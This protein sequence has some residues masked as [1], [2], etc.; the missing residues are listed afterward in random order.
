M[1]DTA[2][3]AQLDADRLSFTRSIRLARRQVTAQAAFSPDHLA[4]FLA[5]GL[6][7]MARHLLP[8]RR[9]RFHPRVLQR[10][11]SNFGGKRDEHRSPPQPDRSPAEAVAIAPHWRTA[12]INP[13][14]KVPR[15]WDP[16]PY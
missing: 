8:D 7:E 12:S 4:A 1:H 14:T 9:R 11:M 16:I 5:E 3:A 10:K 2:D 6:R 15:S 13:P